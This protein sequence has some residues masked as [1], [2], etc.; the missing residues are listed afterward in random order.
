LA[1][2]ADSPARSPC[3]PKWTRKRTLPLPTQRQA[4]VR[5]AS[6]GRLARKSGHVRGQFV[7]KLTISP[8]RFSG[9]P[10]RTD[11]FVS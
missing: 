10:P 9:G 6:R 5:C 7:S 1:E 11:H 8:R 4:I 2:G 3:E